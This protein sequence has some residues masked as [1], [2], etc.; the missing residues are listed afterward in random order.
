MT[1]GSYNLGNAPAL[2]SKAR[3]HLLRL[4]LR[5]GPRHVDRLPGA[6]LALRARRQGPRHRAGLGQR[7]RQQGLRRHRVGLEEVRRPG[8]DGQ[9]ADPVR[10]AQPLQRGVQD[11]EPHAEPDCHAEPERR[12]QGH[13]HQQERLR[14]GRGRLLA[15]VP[16]L[17]RQ[18]QVVRRADE[19]S[20]QRRCR[21]WPV[22][23]RPRCRRTSRRCPR[24]C[25]SSTSRSFATAR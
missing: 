10:H 21:P 6:G 7:R 2:G 8:L 15:A 22:A 23:P 9:Q 11:L 19:P 25:T 20:T 1:P 4:R 24:G 13:R 3:L 16:G 17:R 5:A 12:H 14:L 18:G